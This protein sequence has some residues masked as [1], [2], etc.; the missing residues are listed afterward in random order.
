MIELI[1]CRYPGCKS[2]VAPITEFRYILCSDH[3][4]V[5]TDRYDITDDELEEDMR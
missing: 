3:D 4:D 2:K 5:D 1:D